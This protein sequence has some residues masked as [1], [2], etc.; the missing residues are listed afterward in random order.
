MRR[1]VIAASLLLSTS[2]PALAQNLDALRDGLNNLPATVLMQDR[3]DLA[4]F[5]DIQAVNGLGENNPSLRPYFRLQVG[6]NINA[7][8]SLPRTDPAEWQEKSGI[9]VDQLRYMTG[10]G[11]PPDVVNL[12]GLADEAATANM[13]A[14]LEARGFETAG[15]PGVIGNGEPMRMAPKQ[16][17]PSDPWRTMIGAAQFA[18]AKGNSVVQAQTPQN[19]LL[20][21]TPQPGL[22]ENSIF[23]TA[24]AGLEQLVG[25]SWI[26]QATVISPLFGLGGVDPALVMAPAA[27]MDETR[28]K[29]EDQM[30]ALGTGIPPYLGGIIADVQGER[31]GV[32]IALAYPDCDIAQAAADLI[33]ARWSEMAGEDAQGQVTAHTADGDAG[34]CAATLS[35]FVDNDNPEFNLAYR[36]VLDAYFNRQPGVLQIGEN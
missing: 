6:T 15:A 13:I 17:D 28:Q 24:L 29:I 7:L 8:D 2:I 32:G 4:Y 1:S 10:Y 18:A 35:V 22:G 34:L 33:G 12:W 25:D 26:I 21:S 20:V 27:D 31:T 16:R 19:A 5:V 9:P 3:G 23:E 11:Q 14:A 36:F 30:A